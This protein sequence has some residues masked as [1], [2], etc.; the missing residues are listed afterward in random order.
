MFETLE[1]QE[2]ENKNKTSRGKTF[3][4]NENKYC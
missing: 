2:N 3:K 1:A 4:Q